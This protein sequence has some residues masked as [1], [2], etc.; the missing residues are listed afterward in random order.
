M[1]HKFYPDVDK[2]VNIRVRYSL[3]DAL[4]DVGGFHDGLALIVRLVVSPLAANFFQYDL[5]KGSKQD[6]P[7]SKLQ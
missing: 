3:W 1:T 4:G 2:Q 5:V 7:Q 6:S